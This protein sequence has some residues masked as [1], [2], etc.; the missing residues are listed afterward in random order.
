MNRDA[1]AEASTVRPLCVVNMKAARKPPKFIPGGGLKLQR[2]RSTPAQFALN[3]NRPTVVLHNLQ[4][5]R[6]AQAG[7]ARCARANLVGAPEPVEYMRQGILL[8]SDSRIGDD[9]FDESIDRRY[10]Y[11]DGTCLGVLDGV[12]Q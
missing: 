8:D 10:G 3:R 12:V 9:D 6:E 5:E 2:K 1:L 11:G 4:C 7:S